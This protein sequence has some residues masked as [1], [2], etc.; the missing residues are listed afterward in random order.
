MLLIT[1]EIRHR[2]NLEAATAR[3]VSKVLEMPLLM[4][5]TLQQSTRTRRAKGKR[6][7]DI[8]PIWY[9]QPVAYQ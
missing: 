3:R 4:S 1:F 5:M 2:S 8:A 9:A 6:K 7:E